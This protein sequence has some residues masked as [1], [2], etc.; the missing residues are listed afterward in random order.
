MG[1]EVTLVTCVSFGA[2]WHHCIVTMFFQ[3]IE[4]S[5]TTPWNAAD[6]WQTDNRHSTN[7][8][9]MVSEYLIHFYKLNSQEAN[10]FDLI[11][12]NSEK[13]FRIQILCIILILKVRTAA[14]QSCK[15]SVP[16]FISS[17]HTNNCG[18][19]SLIL[20]QSPLTPWSSFIPLLTSEEARVVLGTVI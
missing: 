17:D 11:W 2:G 12:H 20:W 19:F 1:S 6:L 8:A 14:W 3:T 4:I 13:V 16:L 7:M 5:I 9:D 15:F 18:A 10:T